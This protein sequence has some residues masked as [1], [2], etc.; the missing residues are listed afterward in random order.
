MIGRA[1]VHRLFYREG[2]T[3]TKVIHDPGEDR[4][5]DVADVE[6]TDESG[7]DEIGCIRCELPGSINR[8]MSLRDH[9][10][11]WT[12]SRRVVSSAAGESQGSPSPGIPDSEVDAAQPCA[13]SVAI[14]PISECPD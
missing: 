5:G 7:R 4:G 10:P 11:E 2:W 13:A 9:R 1:E 8:R 3:R 14:C 6:P 12:L